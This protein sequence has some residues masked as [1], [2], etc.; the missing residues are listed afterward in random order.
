MVKHPLFQAG[1]VK[2]MSFV[3]LKLHYSLLIFKSL[4]TDAAVEALL[5]DERAESN[6]SKLSVHIWSPNTTTIEPTNIA[7]WYQSAK[8]EKCEANQEERA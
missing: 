5:K 7:Q 6:L 4:H 2:N 8:E 3:A 1:P